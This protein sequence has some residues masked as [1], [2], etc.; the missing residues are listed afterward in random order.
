MS[1]QQRTGKLPS[2]ETGEYQAN[3][4]KGPRPR[5]EVSELR[6]R[7]HTPGPTCAIFA[8]GYSRLHVTAVPRS[9]LPISLRPLRYPFGYSRPLGGDGHTKAAR[10]TRFIADCQV[11]RSD[12]EA[13][14]SAFVLDP[15]ETYDCDHAGIEL[16]HAFEAASYASVPG[17]RHYAG[18]R[19]TTQDHGDEIAGCTR[20]EVD[21]RVCKEVEYDATGKQVGFG[22]GLSDGAVLPAVGEVDL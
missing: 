7:R 2:D 13:E 10:D 8:A 16:V 4:A 22:P 9:F 1:F 5:H 3:E 11:V 17:E 20:A 6:R 21:L 18:G 14:Q 12:S 15:K 19:G